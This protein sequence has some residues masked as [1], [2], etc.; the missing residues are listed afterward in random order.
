MFVNRKREMEFLERVGKQFER[1]VKVP[2]AIIGLRRIGKTELIQKFRANKSE[3]LMPYMN[4]EGTTSSPETYAQDFYLAFLKEILRTKKMRFEAVGSKREQIIAISSKLGEGIYFKSRGLISAVDSRDYNELLKVCFSLPEE[5][6]EELKTKVMF[7]VDEFQ[8]FDD[9][10]NY[11]FGDVFKIMRSV[12]EKQKNVLYVISGSVISFM[13]RVVGDPAKPF[14]NQFRILKLRYFTK[15]DS[16]KLV[17][18]LLK[19]VEIDEKTSH[20]IF[21]NTLGHPFYITAICERIALES[22]LEVDVD[23][24]RYA[25]LKEILDVNGK[26]NILFKYIFEN[27]LQKANRKGH[28]KEILVY[29]AENEG[30]TLSEI[31]RYLNKPSGQVSNYLSSLLQ[32]DL[33]FGSEKKYYYR[34]AIFK[35]WIAKTQLGKDIGISREKKATD[36][37][38]SELEEKYMRASTELGRA[39]EYEFKVKLEKALG[40][41]LDN[42]IS[43]D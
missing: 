37:Y 11:R 7:F 14:F 30:A 28:L 20:E 38:I 41:K 23:L 18:C 3:I 17:K 25:T 22:A 4:L 2:I 27:S 21:K 34:D 31:A 10:N 13:E 42:Y 35:F 6:A 1:G 19:G 33:I 39:K 9:L 40:L 26:I 43:E 29:L 15:E 24:V 32:T 36:D 12:V 5:I 8:E 16:I